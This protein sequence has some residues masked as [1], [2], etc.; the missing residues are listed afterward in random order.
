MRKLF[1]I[2]ISQQGSKPDPR[3]NWFKGHPLIHQDTHRTL[4][5]VYEADSPEAALRDWSEDF[6]KGQGEARELYNVEVFEISF[7]PTGVLREE[8]RAIDLYAEMHFSAT[9]S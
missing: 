3:S 9:S 1:I 4:S 7:N 5:C 6:Y 8:L 2:A